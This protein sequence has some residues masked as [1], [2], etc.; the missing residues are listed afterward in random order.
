VVTDRHIK[1]VNKSIG[2]EKVYKSEIQP[3]PKKQ[4]KTSQKGPNTKDV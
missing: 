1:S 4:K 2:I 3:T